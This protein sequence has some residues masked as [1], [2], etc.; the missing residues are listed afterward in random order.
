MGTAL[1]PAQPT[2][3]HMI[4]LSD[5]TIRRGPDERTLDE[6]LAIDMPAAS[7][8]DYVPQWIAAPSRVIALRE[9][10]GDSAADADAGTVVLRP[11]GESVVTP[12]RRSA[13]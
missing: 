9:A 2:Y 8:A 11:F 12:S 5:L 13:L 10:L 1:L 7:L 4:S 6:R 3:W